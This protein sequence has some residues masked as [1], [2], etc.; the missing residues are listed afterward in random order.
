MQSIKSRVTNVN[1]RKVL[2]NSVVVGAV[3]AV[4][5]GATSAVAAIVIPDNSI[6]SAKV[7]NGSLNTIDLDK[8][9]LNLLAN[10]K[11]GADQIDNSNQVKAKT[12][13]ETDLNDALA[14][15]V[16][17]VGTGQP[18]KSYGCDGELVDAEH[19]A[20]KCPGKDG[21]D[22]TVAGPA[23]P[24][25]SDA[26]GTLLVDVDFA[27]KTVAN[28]GGTFKTQKTLLGEFTL[29]VGENL[30]IDSQLFGARTASGAPGTIA[31][32]AL[33]VGASETEFGDA[34]GTI[35][36]PLPAFKGREVTGSAFYVAKKV[37]EPT[38]VK[39]YGFCYNDNAEGSADGSGQWTA[40]ASVAVTQG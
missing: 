14:A 2:R 24:A 25:A 29:P 20:A 7:Q 40:Q 1:W 15:K 18:G 9:T 34:Y 23:G 10:T 8:A 13:D 33:R 36:T 27:A 28:C 12:I 21:A 5:F 31:Q 3:M 26:K 35:L 19:P 32:L 17:T 11:P 22:S 30:K 39:L 4:C 38:K 6:N 37:T 16:N